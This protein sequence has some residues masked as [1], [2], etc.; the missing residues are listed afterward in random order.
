[1]CS[2]TLIWEWWVRSG[3]FTAY[4]P[5]RLT[6]SEA[7]TFMGTEVLALQAM[8]RSET[9]A[10]PRVVSGP[11]MQKWFTMESAFMTALWQKAT[12]SL[13][14]NLYLCLETPDHLEQALSTC[15]SLYSFEEEP[16]DLESVG[17][18]WE[19]G[20]ISP[21]PLNSQNTTIN[22]LRAYV[23]Q[24]VC[25]LRIVLFVDLKQSTWIGSHP[26]VCSQ[27]SDTLP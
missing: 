7:A 25:G 14:L 12:S 24:N 2:H 13:H 9:E 1:M 5:T 17:G 16:G 20:K 6:L 11:L 26:Y 3:N 21:S 22:T 18:A 15:E 23:G 27:G 10:S 19:N 4:L 8:G